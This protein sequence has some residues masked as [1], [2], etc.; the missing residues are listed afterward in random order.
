MSKIILNTH[1]FITK[2]QKIFDNYTNKKQTLYVFQ[3]S[4]RLWLFIWMLNNIGVT[5]LNKAAFAKVDFRYPWVLSAIH[6]LCN[7]MGSMYVFYS[8]NASKTAYDKRSSDNDVTKEKEFQPL[9]V[10]LLGGQHIQ[11]KELDST[12]YRTM[13]AFSVLFTLNIALFFFACND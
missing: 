1:H 4:Y 11:R 9:I 10:R 6:M 8:I 3:Y 5:L 12:G 13:M 7:Y 2:H